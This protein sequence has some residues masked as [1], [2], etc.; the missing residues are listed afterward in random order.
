MRNRNIFYSLMLIL[1]TLLINISIIYFIE[2]TA[3]N[4][5]DKVSGYFSNRGLD[6]DIRVITYQHLSLFFGFGK[7]SIAN[8]ILIPILIILIFSKKI[9][10]YKSEYFIV[11]ITILVGIV[12]SIMGKG[13]SRYPG[14]ILPLI[15]FFIVHYLN[16]IAKVYHLQDVIKYYLY[17]LGIVAVFNFFYITFFSYMT[18]KSSEK[19]T[20]EAIK[21]QNVIDE[22]IKNL[23]NEELLEIIE[24]YTLIKRM[25]SIKIH[26]NNANEDS[27]II[28]LS[29]R[30]DIL[31]K[32]DIYK[33]RRNNMLLQVQNIS[34][35]V[36]KYK[37]NIN[38]KSILQ[39]KKDSLMVFIDYY[40]RIENMKNHISERKNNTRKKPSDYKNKNSLASN[41]KIAGELP[42]TRK[43]KDTTRKKL[44]TLQKNK[45]KNEIDKF[46]KKN[47]KIDSEYKLIQDTTNIELFQED[48]SVQIQ[49][50]T[51]IELFQED[52]SVQIQDTTNIELFQEDI[53]VQ[54]QDTTNIELF[55]EDISVQIQ[56]TTNIELFQEDISVQI[57]D[58]TN[59]EL[60]QEYISAKKVV[61]KDNKKQKLINSELE[62]KNR[63]T[64]SKTKRMIKKTFKNQEKDYHNIIRYKV[65]SKNLSSGNETV[66]AEK[67]NDN[68]IQQNNK[69]EKIRINNKKE[70]KIIYYTL[71]DRIAN[72]IKSLFQRIILFLNVQ[73]SNKVDD[74]VDY[75]N[76]INKKEK[77]TFYI[78]SLPEIAYYFRSK[79][80][81]YGHTGKYYTEFGRKNF[82]YDKDIK[83]DYIIT[84]DKYVNLFIR[85]KFI[86]YL[87]ENYLMIFENNFGYRIYKLIR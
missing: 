9:N 18:E 38:N 37:N 1:L 83:I 31:E 70:N 15:L 85:D 78:Y 76:R 14:F 22:E 5:Y 2:N 3:D 26:N 21:N 67:F 68:I 24:Y 51:N 74:I 60:F 61:L 39:N 8:W 56:D 40:A 57:Q 34:N 75:M 53:S 36:G 86:D 63:K 45:I 41:S 46:R 11:L 64:Q 71:I 84:N 27:V 42:Q 35:E 33:K 4:N 66:I 49:D 30:K 12:F 48:I 72:K 29:K 43:R 13:N 77:A 17:F 62:L 25:S 58:T 79:N 50:T 65:T 7:L 28:D 69:V 32:K 19:W 10:I 20:F 87:N 80:Y 52:I 44:N 82:I 73:S 16:I 47:P 81:L 6:N 23:S 55:Q 54:I 59:I